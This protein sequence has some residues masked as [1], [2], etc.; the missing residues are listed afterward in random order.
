MLMTGCQMRTYL[1]ANI[2]TPCCPTL[3]V[4]SLYP[5]LQPEQTAPAQPQAVSTR[6]SGRLPED[7]P[8]SLYYPNLILRVAPSTAAASQHQEIHLLF[9]VH[10]FCGA[11]RLSYPDFPFSQAPTPA[12]FLLEH[13][14]SN[15]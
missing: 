6:R 15:T 8:L 2:P 4:S 12:S 1:K 7:F 5:S 14:P 11:F 10:A 13:Q 3:P 9:P